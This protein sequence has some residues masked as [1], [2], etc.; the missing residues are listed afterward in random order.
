MAFS[1][2]GQTIASA[3][4]DRT[5]KLWNRQGEE[6]LTLSGHSSRVNSVAFSPD[7]Q[8]IASASWDNTVKLWN[9]QGEELLSLL[10]HD[11]DVHNVVFS[12]DGRTIAS[13]SGD[14]QANASTITSISRDNTV[15]L[16]NL[17]DIGFK[18]PPSKRMFLVV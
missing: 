4:A 18:F 11:D 14:S 10:S 9:R 15:K 13:A 16:F 1:P 3:S 17:D 6:L 7:G 8:I 5:I 12:P 2:D